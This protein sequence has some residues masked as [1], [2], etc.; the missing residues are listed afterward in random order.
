MYVQLVLATPVFLLG[1]WHFGRSALASLRTG[2][3]NMDVLIFHQAARL[4]LLYSLAGTI[5]QLG[6]D[7]M[8]YETA[9]TIITLVLLGNVIEKAQCQKDH[10]RHC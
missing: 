6:H 10:Y 4:H 1:V 3:P 5:L 2:V 9:A 8:F 7:Y